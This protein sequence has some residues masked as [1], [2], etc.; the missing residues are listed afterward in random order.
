ME[1]K[2][3]DFFKDY[4]K[5][6]ESVTTLEKT[7]KNPFYKSMYV[8]LPAVLSACKKAAIE[9]NFILIQR[10]EELRLVTELVHVSGEKIT[11][12]I[13]IITKDI[14]DPQK[15][16]AGITYMRR[17][18]LT[19]LFGFA[20]ADDDGNIASNV[21]NKV[22]NKSDNKEY[23]TNEG[24]NKYK[25]AEWYK[26]YIKTGEEWKIVCNK[27]GVKKLGELTKK[28]MEEIERRCAQITDS[29][30]DS[31]DLLYG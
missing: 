10:I 25:V 7:A 3:T 5:L 9:N 21:T 28:Q 2:S 15:V 31:D 13:P 14:S 30:E 18:S 11:S 8:P 26:K 20:E 4:K 23:N 27:Y 12:I 1:N 16:G 22:Y 29:Y 17:Y 19:C 6:M 24:N